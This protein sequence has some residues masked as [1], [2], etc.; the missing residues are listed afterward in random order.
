MC[1]TERFCLLCPLFEVSTIRG[2]T[3]LQFSPVIDLGATG[4]LPTHACGLIE[5]SV[6]FA[7]A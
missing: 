1:V 3:V 5:S 4:V 2:S 6:N 7:S